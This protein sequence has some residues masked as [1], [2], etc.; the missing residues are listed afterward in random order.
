[1]ALRLILVFLHPHQLNAL[2]RLSCSAAAVVAF[3]DLQFARSNLLRLAPRGKDASQAA[4]PSWSRL[5]F[6]K[7]D[8]VYTVAVLIIHAPGGIHAPLLRH[9]LLEDPRTP[10]DGKIG[11]VNDPARL[12]DAVARAWAISSHRWKVERDGW[13]LLKWLVAVDAWEVVDAMRGEME[14]CQMVRWACKSGSLA[15]LT[16][17]LKSGIEVRVS[18]ARLLADMANKVGTEPFVTACEHGHEACVNLLLTSVEHDAGTIAWGIKVSS[19]GGHC[20]I[21]RALLP[22]WKRAGVE[23]RQLQPHAKDEISFRLYQGFV[24]ACERCDDDVARVLMESMLPFDPLHDRCMVMRIACSH[25]RLPIVALLLDWVTQ[26][27][28]GQ[29]GVVSFVDGST[30]GPMRSERLVDRDALQLAHDMAAHNHHDDVAHLFVEHGLVEKPVS[31][32]LIFQTMSPT[33][34]FALDPQVL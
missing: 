17:L 21:L 32:I 10:C 9:L 14:T 11:P 7:L 20:A 15:C 30:A 3:T 2:R 26:R 28:L 4:A 24:A 5:R 18:L 23:W 29:E 12:V 8:G 34:P 31:N 25:G 16:G 22:L 33:D 6:D 1:D 13:C 19:A 27:S